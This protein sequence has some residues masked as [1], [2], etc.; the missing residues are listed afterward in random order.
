MPDNGAYFRGVS[1]VIKKQDTEF[2]I[3]VVVWLVTIPIAYSFWASGDENIH[4]ALSTPN[5]VVAAFFFCLYLAGHFL[6]HGVFGGKQRER[7]EI[8]GLLISSAAVAVL[9]GAFFFF[10]MMGC[11]AMMVI[12]KLASLIEQKWAMV[13][14]V[15]VPSLLVLLEVLLGKEFD[16]TTIV[17]FGTVNVLALSASYRAISERNAKLDSEQL[18]RELK[19]TQILLSATTKRDERLRIARN[20]HDTMGHQLTALSLQLE[21][22][23]H[24]EGDAKKEHI[25]KAQMIGTALLSNVRETVSEFRDERDLKLHEA[26]STLIAGIPNLKIRLTV[27]W[28]ESLAKERQVEVLFRSAQEALTNVARHSDATRCDITVSSDDKNLTLVVRDNG[29]VATEIKPGN[30]LKGMAERVNKIDGH[31]HFENFSDG[32]VLYVKLPIS[33]I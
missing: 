13:V 20:L 33:D 8:F 30:G 12:I 28:E 14:A 21:V 31:L 17:I 15:A 25:E 29:T 11:M 10:A 23:S 1:V 2:Y 24:V 5:L 16:F 3:G 9:S 7:H 32:F 19:A 4:I 18:V 26:L 6:S 22:A 27:D